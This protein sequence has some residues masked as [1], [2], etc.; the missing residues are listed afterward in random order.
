MFRASSTQP[1][2]LWSNSLSEYTHVN[3]AF[4]NNA[5]Q[6]L[7]LKALSF[8]TFPKYPWA[9]TVGHY[10]EWSVKGPIDLGRWGKVMYG[11]IGE[12]ERE[13]RSEG[14]YDMCV[15][16]AG[17]LEVRRPSGTP[18]K[19]PPISFAG[20]EGAQ[21]AWCLAALLVCVL[22]RV[23]TS[24]MASLKLLKSGNVVLAQIFPLPDQTLWCQF[25]NVE[26]LTVG[27]LWVGELTVENK[28]PRVHC[29]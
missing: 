24:V 13:Q 23:Q 5:R 10:E 14:M 8:S 15:C 4:S 20:A 3:S 2:I 18:P 25:L 28:P 6:K 26:W 7:Q 19:H 11:L 9:Q 12:W 1:G 21:W 17:D 27:I 16:M 29:R 22:F